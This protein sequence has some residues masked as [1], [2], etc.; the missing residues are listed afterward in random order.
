M[1]GQDDSNGSLFSYIDLE[2][3]VPAKHPL[4]LIRGIVNAVLEAEV[5]AKLLRGVIEHGRVRRLLSREHFS[6]DG[7]LIEAW[8]SMKARIPCRTIKIPQ[9]PLKSREVVVFSAA[10]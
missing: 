7:T 5:S 1:R 9:K 4:R 6:V 2:D 3:R 8:A 10:C